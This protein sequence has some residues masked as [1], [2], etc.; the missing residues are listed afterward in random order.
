M[1]CKATGL[2]QNVEGEYL[3]SLIF[4]TERGVFISETDKN[5]SPIFIRINTG[6][7]V[8]AIVADLS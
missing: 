1:L 4:S 6:A 8:A 7:A 2:H 5:Q 3:K